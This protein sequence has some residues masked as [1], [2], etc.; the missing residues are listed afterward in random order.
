LAV[1]SGDASFSGQSA[2]RAQARQPLP[3]LVK[4]KGL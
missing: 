4:G 3:E 2:Y 1:F